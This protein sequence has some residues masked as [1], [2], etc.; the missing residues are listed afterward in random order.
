LAQHLLLLLLLLLL[1]MQL[2]LWCLQGPQR[3]LTVPLL[4]SLPL[5]PAGEAR[6]AAKLGLCR[7]LLLPLLR[8]PL[9]RVIHLHLLLLLL[10]LLVVAVLWCPCYP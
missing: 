3:C 2:S 5:A 4:V 10:L 8:Q 6:R 9:Q 1:H 7:L